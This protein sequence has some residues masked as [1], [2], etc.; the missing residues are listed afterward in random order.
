MKP[1]VKHIII[2]ALLTAI[3]VTFH[4]VRRNSTMRGIE[5]HIAEDGI[6][7]LSPADIDSLIVLSHPHIRQTDIKDIDRKAI[8][9]TLKQHPYVADATARLSTGGK[10]LV[11]VTP[12]T[13]V[14]R[15][16]Y[17]GNE[18]YI[19]QKGTCM[20]LCAKKFCNILIGNV[21]LSEPLLANTSALNLADT[22]NHNQPSSLLKIW[23]TAC[24]LNDNPKYGDIF[25][26]VS[27]AAN[28][29]ICLIPKLGELT[30][31]LGDTTQMN[32][33]FENLWAFLDQ[34]ISLVGWDTYSVI[35][36]KYR[37][38]VVCTKKK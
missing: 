10:L 32:T 30:V 16:F 18:F 21:N 22:A 25:D 11:D 8:A 1:T 26:Q 33:K 2:I 12:N 28:G 20:P 3:V 23:K 4:I 29:D 36:L 9:E 35:N 15:M 17:Q 37:N 34:G 31:I 7:L 6:G 24:F 38:Q 5:S 13:P 27:I 19:S 14:V